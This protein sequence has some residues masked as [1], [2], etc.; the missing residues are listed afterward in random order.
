MGVN[1]ALRAPVL[2]DVYIN[3]AGSWGARR[4]G[5]R[6]P[7]P[8]IVIE[9]ISGSTLTVSIARLVSAIA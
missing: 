2:P 9:P 5:R 7:Q 8:R 1:G 3:M 4:Q 6:I